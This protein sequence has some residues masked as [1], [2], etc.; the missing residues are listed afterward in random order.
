VGILF[1]DFLGAVGAAVQEH[2]DL[3]NEM[4][5]LEAVF[6]DLFFVVRDNESRECRPL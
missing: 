5:A 4:Q 2:H 6:Q 1:G 3:V